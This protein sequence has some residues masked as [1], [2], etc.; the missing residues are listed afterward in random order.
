MSSSNSP[1]RFWI[2]LALGLILAALTAT[3]LLASNAAAATQPQDEVD[4]EPLGLFFD[5]D[6]AE[7]LVVAAPGG[8]YIYVGAGNGFVVLDVSDASSPH[9]IG[10]LRLKGDKILDIVIRNATAYVANGTGL[11]V[12]NIADPAHPTLAGELDLAGNTWAL[13]VDGSQ[14]YIVASGALH[15]VDVSNPATPVLAG[16]YDLAGTVSNIYAAGGVGST[17]SPRTQ[18]RSTAPPSR[19][20]P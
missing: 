20:S 6:H 9:S 13:G 16:S 8:D 15:T 7:T 2:L 11:R 17:A 5:Y 3:P 10:D 19:K 18:G 1:R 12:V 14:A 4:F